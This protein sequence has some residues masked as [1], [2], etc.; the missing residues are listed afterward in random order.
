MPRKSV[1]QTFSKYCKR[2]GK[3]FTCKGKYCLVCENCKVTRGGSKM[4]RPAGS[5]SE[6]GFPKNKEVK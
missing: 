5:I 3:V 2:C 6:W 4:G 1:K